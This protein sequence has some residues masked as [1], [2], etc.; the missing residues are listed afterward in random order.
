MAKNAKQIAT[1]FASIIDAKIETAGNENLKKNWTRERGKFTDPKVCAYYAEHELDPEGIKGLAIY[2]AQKVRKLLMKHLGMA[3]KIDPYTL[4]TL[5]NAVALA[6]Q[7]VKFTSELQMAGLCHSVDAADKL[8]LAERVHKDRATAST[9]TS[10]TRA[11]LEALGVLQVTKEDGKRVLN[12][13]LE[14]PIVK[15]ALG[16]PEPAAA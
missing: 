6:K 8:K 15:S 11:A 12:I 9:Q 10:S 4:N 7:G 2:A 16:T 13:D 5:R 1:T 3:E 14:H